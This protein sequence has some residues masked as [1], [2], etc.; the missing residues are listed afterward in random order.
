MKTNHA[1]V[2]AQHFKQYMC[3][4]VRDIMSD[5]LADL[6]GGPG[7]SQAGFESNV[8]A[9]AAWCDE[10]VT[11]VWLDTQCDA[12]LES[13]PEWEED[14]YGTP[15]EPMWEDYIHFDTCAVKRA[16]FGSE[17]SQYV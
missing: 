16:I 17:L 4:N 5:A 11:K 1:Q 9:L 7:A 6:Y 8:R 13:E 14:A 12:V 3:A 10:Y 15:R 2:I